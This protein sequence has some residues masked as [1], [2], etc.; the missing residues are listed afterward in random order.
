MGGKVDGI[1]E[2]ER[3]LSKLGDFPKEMQRELRDSNRRIA[4]IGAKVVKSSLPRQSREFVVYKKG[5]PGIGAKGTGEVERTIPAGTLKRSIRVWNV[6]RS[7]INVHMGVKRGGSMR[8]NGYFAPWVE[9]GNV[10]KRRRS[11]GSKFYDSITPRLER[12]RGRIQRIQLV[13]YRR[14]FNKYAISLK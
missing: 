12:V 10:G 3:K 11:V 6:R 13:A 1:R 5:K 14:L 7:K 8:F 9:G 2:L 4:R